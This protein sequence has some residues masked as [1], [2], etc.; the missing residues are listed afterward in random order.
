VRIN[1]TITDNAFTSK[2]HSWDNDFYLIED[3][4][5][6]RNNT[7]SSMRWGVRVDGGD[8]TQG[9]IGKEWHFIGGAHD[10]QYVG[11]GTTD[12]STGI[13]LETG[14]VYD[15]TIDVDPTNN[16]PGIGLGTWV[17]TIVMNPAGGGDPVSYTSPVMGWRSSENE[18]GGWLVFATRAGELEDV[19]DWSIDNI[20][21]TQGPPPAIPGDTD[22]NGIVNEI[23]AQVLA[24]K[25]GATVSNGAEDGDF[26]GDTLVNVLDAAIL[27]ANWGNHNGTEAATAAPEPSTLLLLFAAAASLL[28]TRRR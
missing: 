11:S 21:I 28:I 22:G 26:N 9:S 19:R 14:A 17:G 20:V 12:G 8:G 10:G 2:F 4:P 6:A 23:D 25:W 7:A 15:F 3:F 16:E 5:G 1:E 27:A 13:P 24:E 18:A